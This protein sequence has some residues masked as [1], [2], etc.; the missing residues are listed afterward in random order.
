MSQR[1]ATLLRFFNRHMR[2]S[3]ML[4]EAKKLHILSQRVAGPIL[5]EAQNGPFYRSVW[6]GRY[7]GRTDTGSSAP[8]LLPT[9]ANTTPSLRHPQWWITSFSLRPNAWEKFAGSHCF[10]R[11]AGKFPAQSISLLW[12]IFGWK[13]RGKSGEEM[14]E[15][16]GRG[17]KR[18]W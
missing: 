8:R 6:Q 10:P 18:A 13:G 9:S 1:L 2:W 5:L 16:R 7:R 12:A 17:E 15:K 11:G 14:R 3:A 4:L